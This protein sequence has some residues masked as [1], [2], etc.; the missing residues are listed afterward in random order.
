MTDDPITHRVSSLESR[1]DYHE[2]WLR[3][4]ENHLK[5]LDADM[6][7]IRDTLASTATK[8]DIAALRNDVLSSINGVLRDALNSVP[9]KQSVMLG[10]LMAAVAV[11]S[12]IFT[13]LHAH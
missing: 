11:A 9:G 12:L 5:Q 4:H 3:D 10:G 2:R 7:E 13:M 1:A 8:E 6:A